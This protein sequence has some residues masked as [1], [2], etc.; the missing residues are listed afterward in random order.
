M[1]RKTNTSQDAYRRNKENFII[2]LS[3]AVVFGLGWGLGL[4]ATSN[5][6]EEVTIGLQVLFSI[7]VGAQGVLLF[8]LHG[9][10]NTDSRKLWKRCFFSMRCTRLLLTVISSKSTARST[11]Y[12]S[13]GLHTIGM[14]SQESTLPRKTE[15]MNQIKKKESIS[16]STCIPEQEQN[17]VEDTDLNVNNI[18]KL[19]MHHA[20]SN[21]GEKSE[22]NCAVPTSRRDSNEERKQEVSNDD[23]SIQLNDSSIKE[24][25]RKESATDVT[26]KEHGSLMRSMELNWKTR[27]QQM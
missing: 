11:S 20:P 27:L 13:N 14:H 7:F 10:R 9:I 15:F 17:D 16:S 19:E 26:N 18:V 12:S 3:L 6:V 21:H 4:L 8:I 23:N 1:K 24:F 25:E 2:A 5:P 22:L